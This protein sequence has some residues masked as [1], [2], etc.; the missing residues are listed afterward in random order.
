MDQIWTI[1]SVAGTLAS[2]IGALYSIYASRRAKSAA[3]IAISARDQI[4]AKKKTTDLVEILHSA[5]RLQKVFVKYTTAQ[6]RKSLSGANFSDD[7]NQLRE[8]ISLLNEKRSLIEENSSFNI[9]KYY[10]ELVELLDNYSGENTVT[11]KQSN[12]KLLIRVI[13]SLIYDL[14]K[15]VD[16]RNEI[17]DV[18]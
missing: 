4:L 14:R 3:D 16:H 5:K 8:F 15:I 9:I 18:S 1:F 13:D 11:N 6:T 10:V 17:L 7:A 12:G 2:I